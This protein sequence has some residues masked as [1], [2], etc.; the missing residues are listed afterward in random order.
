MTE[1]EIPH[2]SFIEKFKEVNGAFSVAEC[3]A[4]YNVCL[5]SPD[6]SW[7]E[8]GTHKGKSTMAIALA[9]NPKTSSLTLV[10]PE[11]KDTNWLEEVAERIIGVNKDIRL[12]MMPSYS[13]DEIKNHVGFIS[14]VFVDS[15]V[16]DDMVMEEVK[17]LEDKIVRKGVIAFHDYK[18]QFTA[19]E[20]AYQYLLS[21]GKYEEIEINWP[22]I[23]REDREEG[24]NSWHQYPELGHAPNFVGALRRK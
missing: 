18:N 16:H 4:L 13:I 17:L 22:L 23:L 8:L 20:R 24:N 21:T 11:F 12:Y 5:Q 15:G 3:I 10:E 6:G 9:M 14:F 7:M 2:S 1:I 19:V